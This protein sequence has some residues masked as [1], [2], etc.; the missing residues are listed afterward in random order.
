MPQNPH[1]ETD[2]SK[3]QTKIQY[4]DSSLPKQTATTTD[5]EYGERT[6]TESTAIKDKQDN[7]TM[8]TTETTDKDRQERVSESDSNRQLQGSESG[9]DRQLQDSENN[10]KKQ[11]QFLEASLNSSESGLNIQ[12]RDSYSNYQELKGI[13]LEIG[14]KKG[15]NTDRPQ[16]EEAETLDYTPL[17]VHSKNEQEERLEKLD[18]IPNIEISEKEGRSEVINAQLMKPKTPLHRTCNND[19]GFIY[20][21]NTSIVIL[22]YIYALYTFIICNKRNRIY[23]TISLII[24]LS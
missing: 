17:P 1:Q 2:E 24:I 13:G 14:S 3:S 21:F 7:E 4:S 18:N 15:S 20:T 6:I 11:I 9:S 16:S 19:Y 5:K 10:S 12:E 23:C 8:R 22:S